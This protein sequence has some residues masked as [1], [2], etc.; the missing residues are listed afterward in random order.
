[1]KNVT[2]HHVAAVENLREKLGDL[3]PPQ[4]NT[5][6]N[7]LRWIINAEKLHG[8]KGSLELAEK[9][10]K[11]HLRYR[12]SM[13]LDEIEIPSM[14][15]N[16]MYI[17][18]IVPRG[19]L[20]LMESKNRFLCWT[21]YESTDAIGAVKTVTTSEVLYGHF[22]LY[23]K[24]LR[25]VNEREQQTGEMSAVDAV[26]DCAHYSMNA[27]VLRLLNEGTCG[28]YINVFLYDHYPQLI[29][30]MWAINFP[31]WLYLPFRV[32]KT[33]LPLDITEKIVVLDSNFR[34]TFQQEYDENE[35]PEY[36]GGKLKD[37]HLHTVPARRFLPEEYYK[38]L[39]TDP[40]MENCTHM[41]IGA[42]RRKF[43]H[44]EIPHGDIEMK[45]FLRSDG[46]FYFGLFLDHKETKAKK[47]KKKHGGVDVDNMEMIHP[48]LRIGARYVPE[49][50]TIY[51][52]QPGSYYFV[53][54]NKQNWLFRCNIYYLFEF[55]EKNSHRIVHRTFTD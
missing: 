30:V 50:G 19:S 44:F 46:D 51:L 10:L 26:L 52:K 25:M 35:L 27:Q 7:L 32:A 6:F 20:T 41:Q 53:F 22:L 29:R 8:I 12:K 45:F 40:T 3:I 39:E 38:P 54:W 48:F 34:S 33:I 18:R 49:R 11:N 15:D 24:L 23:E 21:D 17:K 16:P 14:E 2:P 43:I 5:N 9:Q 31:R 47:A 42:R 13:K 4:Y 37:D 36:L 1:M 55:D 28:Y